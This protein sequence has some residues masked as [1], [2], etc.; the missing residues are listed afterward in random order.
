M[1]TSTKSEQAERR[2]AKASLRYV[3]TIEDGFTRQRCGKGFRYRTSSGKALTS[4][5]HLRRIDSL[6]IP[7]A[8]TDVFICR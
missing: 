5:R 3:D 1:A 2:A 8:W 4:D 6:V 7:P